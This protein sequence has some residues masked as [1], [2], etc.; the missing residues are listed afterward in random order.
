[1]NV[2]EI[3]ATKRDSFKK[4][5]AKLYRRQGLI[6]SIIYGQEENKNVLISKNEF[7]KLSHHLTKSTIVK[8]KLDNKTYEVLVK[9]Y[10]KDYIK[11]E[12]LHIDFYELKSGKPVH[13]RI[14]LN[15]VGNAIGIKEGGVLEKHLTSIDVECLPKDIVPFIDINIDNMKIGDAL[16]VKDVQFDEKYKVLSHADDVLVHI[17]GKMAEEEVAVEEELEGEVEGEAAVE[18]R[19]EEKTETE[20]SKEK[21]EQNK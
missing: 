4:G 7:N 14:S 12:F 3:E 16:H 21:T 6:P 8:I 13:S 9:D 2:Y 10:Q 18:E 15:F 5:P 17:S 19:A 20:P 11:D 1:M